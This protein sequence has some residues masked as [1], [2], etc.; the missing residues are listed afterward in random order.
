MKLPF[1][2]K[3]RA[4]IHGIKCDPMIEAIS[5][6]LKSQLDSALTYHSYEHSDDVTGMAVALAADDGIEKHDLLLLGIAAAYHDSG[7]IEQRLN[8]EEI[9]AS[10]AEEA[11]RNDV[12][13][14]SDDIKLT[15][16]MILDTKLQAVGMSHEINTRLSPWLIDA[17]LSNLG[18]P[19]FILQTN[20]LA[21]ELNIP[22]DM[23]FKESLIL[24]DRHEWHSPAGRKVLGPQKLINKEALNADLNKNSS[25]VITKTN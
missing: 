7:F 16:Q 17:D 21:D 18:R 4:Q 1:L 2:E 13:F 8:H 5:I 3:Y 9:G 15:R 23:M 22:I 19:N 25:E 6:T 12:R 11:M 10:L 24:M 14:S 20:L